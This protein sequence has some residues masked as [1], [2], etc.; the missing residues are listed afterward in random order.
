[1]CLLGMQREA[2]TMLHFVM[3]ESGYHSIEGPSAILLGFCFFNEP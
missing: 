1:M 2:M 3:S